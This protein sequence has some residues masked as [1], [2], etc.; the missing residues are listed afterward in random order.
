VSVTLHEVGGGT[1]VDIRHEGWGEGPAW[2]VAI[3]GHFAG[4]LQGLAALGL[5]LEA[6]VDAR[7]REA[8]LSALERY[9]I[10]GEL[11]AT[12]AP[13][14]RALTDPLVR[15]RWAGA[16]AGLLDGA[17]LTES[18]DNR[19]ARW[20]LTSGGEITAILRVTPRGTH[21][22]LAEHGV[23]GRDASQRWPAMFEALARF[24]V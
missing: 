19:F 9:F 16:V 12:S 22:A 6:G 20:R 7:V 14:F 1:R 5:V 17:V 13:V 10:S 18:V 3:Q 21:V 4:W 8:S 11:P 2:D 15:A 24:L 23:V